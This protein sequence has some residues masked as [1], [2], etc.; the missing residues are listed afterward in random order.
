MTDPSPETTSRYAAEQAADLLACPRC[1]VAP[2]ARAAH[3]F[4][5][6]SCGRVV[7]VRDDVLLVSGGP[8]EAD[9]DTLHEVMQENNEQDVIWRLMYERQSRLVE[10]SLRPGMVLLDVGCGPRL[11]YRPNSQV[12]VVGV[13]PSFASIRRNDDLDLRL[14]GGAGELPLRDGSVDLVVCFYSI[15]HMIGR[16]VAATRANVRQAFEEFARVVKPGGRVLVFEVCP[17]PP[18][19]IAQRIG[20]TLARRILGSSINFFFWSKE[21]L[22]SLGCQVMSGAQVRRQT[23]QCSP[24]AIFPPAFALQWLRMPRFLYP[25]TV[26]LSEWEFA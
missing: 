14:C 4:E 18:F 13:E 9:F 8:D 17:W 5:C 11:P 24:F 20:W 23:F 21:E 10:E 25:F 22:R 1:R 6:R 16:D 26:T 19:R 2:L 7:P 3:S 15:H 12:V